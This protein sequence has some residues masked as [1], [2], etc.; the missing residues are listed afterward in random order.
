MVVVAILSPLI[1]VFLGA[2]S[3][4]LWIDDL[5]FVIIIRLSC[6]QAF[7]SCFVFLHGSVVSH[8]HV[9]L[10]ALDTVSD[11]ILSFQA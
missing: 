2:V 11:R 9:E 6:V 5:G 10:N 3:A 8:L 1:Q 7:E 4:F